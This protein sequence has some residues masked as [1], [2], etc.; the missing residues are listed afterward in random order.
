MGKRS[1]NKDKL[2]KDEPIDVV[3]DLENQLDVTVN[4]EEI[5]N[6]KVMLAL[7]NSDEYKDADEDGKKMLVQKKKL[8]EFD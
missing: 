2:S 6:L 4:V 1:P 8:S 5:R 3:E 7:Y